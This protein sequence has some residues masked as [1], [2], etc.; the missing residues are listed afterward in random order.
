MPKQSNE[1]GVIVFTATPEAYHLQIVSVPEGYEYD[2]DFELYTEA[3]SGEYAV[4][5]VKK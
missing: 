4:N 3:R 5:I 2:E 1:S